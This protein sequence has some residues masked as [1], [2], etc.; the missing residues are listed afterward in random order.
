MPQIEAWANFYVIMGSAAGAL[1]GLTFIVI[2]LVAGRRQTGDAAWGVG[3]FTSPTIANFS[4]VLVFSIVIVAPW[5]AAWQA[6]LA[7][8]L[9]AV[10]G[11]GYTAIVLRRMRGEGNYDPVWEDWLWF[12]AIPFIA[13]IALLIAAALIPSHERPALFLTA[14]SLLLL[15]I[16]CIHN[17]WDL[18]IYIAI[19]DNAGEKDGD[20]EVGAGEE[21][22]GG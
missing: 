11:V 22:A 4:A 8:A 20:G 13:Y 18:V 9:G 21:G 5:T 19:F 12:V 7:L 10:W 3:S 15:L 1:T 17:A 6:A 2:T 14:A 16:M